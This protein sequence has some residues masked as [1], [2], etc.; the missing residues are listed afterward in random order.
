MEDED[1][2]DALDSDAEPNLPPIGTRPAGSKRAE[3]QAEAGAAQSDTD[4]AQQKLNPNAKDFKSFFSSMR[5]S[6]KDKTKDSEASA[7]KTPT[8]ATP[9]GGNTPLL[10]HQHNDDDISPPASRKSKDTRSM[11]TIESST[12][13]A[14]TENLA[15][16]SSYSNAS[17]TN[18]NASPLIGAGSFGKESFMQKISRKSSSGKFSL[19]TFKREKSRLEPGN[20]TTPT[21]EDV[22]EETAMGSSTGS[23]KGRTWSTV[24][25]LGKGKE[26]KAGGDAPSVS[27]LSVASGADEEEGDEEG[28]LEK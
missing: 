16:T 13:D 25:K 18:S 26:R 23:L 19:P 4:A 5:L 9:A 28:L 20:A 1:D 12:A 21:A 6:S 10:N 24:L 14:S 11:T 15:R 3:K 8:S 27:G 17:D 2:T 22:D 7:S